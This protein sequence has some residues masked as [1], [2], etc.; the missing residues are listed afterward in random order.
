M[1]VIALAWPAHPDWPLVLLANRDEFH[2]R[3]S[4]PAQWWP[5]HPGLL[6][7]RDL[8]AGGSWLAVTRNGRF[9]VITNLPERRAGRRSELSRGALVTGFVLDQAAPLPWL[10]SLAEHAEDYAG[11]CLLAG[12]RT[13]L[14]VLDSP[15]SG[16][17][18]A[19]GQGLFAMSNTSLGQPWPK[20]AALK[21]RLA[22][23][24][25]SPTA[26]EA[27]SLLQL[28]GPPAAGTRAAEPGIP[29]GPRAEDIF[30]VGE[31]YGTRASTLLRISAAGDCEFIERRFAADTTVTGETRESFR[32]GAAADQP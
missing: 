15:G 32:I 31:H 30:V 11:F 23:L 25:A 10:A 3:P 16:Q 2:A 1:C 14:A 18:Q 22:Q 12:D 13:R 26:A 7:G 24:L 8:R 20:V 27:E 19:L 28:I 5:D 4:A 21:A 29:P 17:A 6:G 9:A